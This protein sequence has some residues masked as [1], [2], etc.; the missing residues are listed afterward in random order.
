MPSDDHPNPSAD[1]RRFLSAVTPPARRKLALQRE[2]TPGVW[3][4]LGLF[5]L[6]GWS[7]AI[8]TVAGGLLGLWW[9]RHHPS[10]PSR[11]LALLVAGLVLGCTNAWLWVMRQDNVMHD[12]EDDAS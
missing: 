7:V 10:V 3:F 9:D 1:E 11:T 5:G 8:P 6:V 4:G 12:R 2:G